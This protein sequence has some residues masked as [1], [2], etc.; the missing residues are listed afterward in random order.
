MWDYNNSWSSYNGTVCGITKI[1]GPATLGQYVGLQ[2]FMVQLHWDSMWHYNNSWSRY[3]GTVC[4]TTTIP[5][6]A[7]MGQ[8]VGLQK[9]ILKELEILGKRTYYFKHNNAITPFC[10]SGPEYSLCGKPTSK[11][12]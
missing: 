1:L 6:P 3:T 11:E 9:F 10:C 5:G 7:I 2:K 4:G 8:Y 12:R